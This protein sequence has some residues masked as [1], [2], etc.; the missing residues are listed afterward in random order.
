MAGH[1]PSAGDHAGDHTTRRA[2]P[3]TDQHRQRDATGQTQ[4]LSGDFAAGAG[5]DGGKQLGDDDKTM[6]SPAFDDAAE[7]ILTV[8]DAVKY[9]DKASA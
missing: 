2:Q 9:I 8:G 1:P 6:L 4:I 5:D 7:T 3:A